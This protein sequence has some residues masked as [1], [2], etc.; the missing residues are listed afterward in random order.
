MKQTIRI[1]RRDGI[2]QRY[3]V[4]QRFKLRIEDY[5]NWMNF[6]D[7]MTDEA[8]IHSLTTQFNEVTYKYAQELVKRHRI[9]AK[10]TTETYQIRNSLADELREEYAQERAE[11]EAEKERKRR[12]KNPR[13]EGSLHEQK[14]AKDRAKAARF[15]EIVTRQALQDA[16]KKKVKLK[17]KP[18]TPNIAQR[19]WE[20]LLKID[21]KERIKKGKT[22]EKK[23]D[24]I[25][26]SQE[27]YKL[28]FGTTKKKK[29]RK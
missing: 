20:K 6:H 21:E 14:E 25:E 18:M 28:E 19:N 15:I 27:L 24:A 16:K 17:T 13:G 10:R 26:A 7:H 3:R 2:V 12:K 22:F 5:N 11:I 4:R 9:H 29:K 8:L 23:L 1:R